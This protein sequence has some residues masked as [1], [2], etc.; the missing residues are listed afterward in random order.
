MLVYVGS[1]RLL[2]LHPL[3]QEHKSLDR[4]LYFPNDCFKYKG[5]IKQCDDG[6]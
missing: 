3:V 4:Q 1:G 5:K 6:L 2:S